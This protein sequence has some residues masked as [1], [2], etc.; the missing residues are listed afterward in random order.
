MCIKGFT[1]GDLLDHPQR[2]TTPLLRGRDGQ[3]AP[4]SWEAALDFVAERLAAPSARRTGR[5][6]WRPS[7]AARSPTRRPTCWASSRAW[8]SARRNIDYNGRYC[9]ASAAAGQNRAFGIDRGLPF[10]VSDIARTKTLL[11]WG[12]NVADTMPP[13]MQWISAQRTRAAS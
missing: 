3:L 9:M 4:A 11:L 12:S 13:L 5:R 1:S 7:A 6:R 10:P 2:V 8:R